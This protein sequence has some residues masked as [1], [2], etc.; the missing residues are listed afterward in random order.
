VVEELEKLGSNQKS[1]LP[2]SPY[3]I[4]SYLLSIVAGANVVEE[5][6]KLGSNQ[7]EGE[8]AN[9]VGEGEGTLWGLIPCANIG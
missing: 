5:L 9:V 8:G 3:L 1:I 2:K 4:L 6:E 7:K